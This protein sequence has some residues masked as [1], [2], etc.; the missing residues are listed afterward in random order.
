MREAG[1]AGREQVSDLMAEVRSEREQEAAT[2]S[3]PEEKI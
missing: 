3:R 1:N 2:R